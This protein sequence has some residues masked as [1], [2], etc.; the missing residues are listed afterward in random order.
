MLNQLENQP[1]SQ[2][3]NLEQLLL[4]RFVSAD[5]GENKKK[6]NSNKSFEVDFLDEEEEVSADKAQKKATPS[7]FK[8]NEN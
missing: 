4:N 1:K 5:S 8:P 3:L 7:K 2:S 6:K